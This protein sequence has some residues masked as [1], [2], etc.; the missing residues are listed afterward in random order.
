MLPSDNQVQINGIYSCD[1]ITDLNR[2]L[3]KC[4]GS[5]HARWRDMLGFCGSRNP[6]CFSLFSLAPSP[7]LSFLPPASAYYIHLPFIF[8]LFFVHFDLVCAS[9]YLSFC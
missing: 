4:Q 3:E 9:S 7:L 8:L 2:P 1:L 6:R 5:V